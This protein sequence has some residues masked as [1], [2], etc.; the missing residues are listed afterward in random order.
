M[1]SGVEDVSLPRPEKS[2]RNFDSSGIT[3]SESEGPAQKIVLTISTPDT[4]VYRYLDF[5]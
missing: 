1:V 4:V 5:K 3:C 2:W